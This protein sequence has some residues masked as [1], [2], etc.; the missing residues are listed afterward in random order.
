MYGWFEPGGGVNKYFNYT[1]LTDVLLRTSESN[2]KIV[3]GNASNATAGIYVNNNK[4]GIRCVPSSNFAMDVADKCRINNLT[5]ST[6]GFN[7]DSNAIHMDNACKLFYNGHLDNQIVFTNHI[8]K[9]K[10]SLSC[11]VIDIYLHSINL[12]R[13]KLQ[14]DASVYDGPFSNGDF[15]RVGQTI[16][17]V[18]DSIGDGIFD[19]IHAIDSQ[20][21][22]NPFQVGVTITI[23][24]FNEFYTD[25]IETSNIW[26]KLMNSFIVLTNSTIVFKVSILDDVYVPNI[27]KSYLY[28]FNLI[29]STAH[30]LKLTTIEK[31]E[32]M[33]YNL[34][35]STVDGRTFPASLSTLLASMYDT[36]IELIM[37]DG[38]V[39]QG[40][41]DTNT[42]WGTIALNADTYVQIKNSLITSLLNQYTDPAYNI[43]EYINFNGI[44]YNVASSS[45]YNESTILKLENYNTSY[46]YSAKGFL[47][48]KMIGIPIY[49]K[50]VE[51]LDY[52]V[53]K[54]TVNDPFE[55]LPSMCRYINHNIYITTTGVHAKILSID[56]YD[57]YIILDKPLNSP[58]DI[59]VN[60]FIYVLPYKQ[61][62]RKVLTEENCFI[63]E[64]LGVG[65]RVPDEMLSVN[66]NASIQNKVIYHNIEGTS[67]FTT[68][69]S[70]NTFSLGEA[71][72]IDSNVTVNRNTIIDGSILA[73]SYLNYSDKRLKKNI[74]KS[75]PRKDLEL[76][77][78]LSVYD[79]VMAMDNT[80]KQKGL[81][82]HEIE[83][84][85]P[86]FV[87][88]INGVVMSVC[89]TCRITNKGSIIIRNPNNPQDFKKFGVLRIHKGVQHK[90]ISILSVLHKKNTLFIKLAEKIYSPSV[91][92]QGPHGD[93]KVIDK[94]S[95]TWMMFNG[96]KAVVSELEQLKQDMKQFAHTQ[97]P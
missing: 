32:D 81:L 73:T 64:K 26:L 77:K 80:R 97:S 13:L 60:N 24:I 78:Q 88:R 91:Y 62:K 20:N 63:G 3:I 65:T 27:I 9:F 86:E 14:Y 36:P 71:I 22:I 30:I 41:T 28:S 33:Q 49:I 2:N 87:Q 37:Q 74:K 10:A 34:T 82:A 12:Y 43:V 50:T 5:I 7:I 1:N 54:Y 70:G 29:N 35:F 66:G 47:T 59:P 89:M 51:T 53:F 93:V 25:P 69:Y 76:L 55:M 68:R 23:D 61:V 40:R 75:S 95:I 15:I 17:K 56:L 16:F 90:D 42:I 58:I 39:P 38:L 8:K 96:M 67:S 52:S 19:I 18:V 57:K 79:F 11:T 31:I 92:V 72:W 44:E 85:K 45:L 83:R 48:F 4:V 21:T 6:D 84:I 94:D 46:A